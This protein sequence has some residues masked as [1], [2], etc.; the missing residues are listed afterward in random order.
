MFGAFVNSMVR[1]ETEWQKILET[2]RRISAELIGKLSDEA[3][4]LIRQLF[5]EGIKWRFFFAER[6]LVPNSKAVLLWLKQYGPV[7]PESFNTIWAPTVPSSE[8]RKAIL[9]ALSFMEFIRL[10][11]G[12]LT[13]TT[14]GSLY[15]KFIGWVKEA[16]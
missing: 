15:L 14:L 2:E 4:K 3:A 10:D 9:D 12:A 7:V 16:V 13:I 1:R 5:D 6:Y 8:E 11:N